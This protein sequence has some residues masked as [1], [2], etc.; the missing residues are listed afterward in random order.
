MFSKG[1]NPHP[2]VEGFRRATGRAISTKKRRQLRFAD[3]VRVTRRLIGQTAGARLERG[4]VLFQEFIPENDHDIRVTVI[5]ERCFVF[6]RDVRPDDFRASGSGRISY[7]QEEQVP[8]DAVELAFSISHEF[9]FQ[10]MAYDFVRNPRDGQLRLL[11]I[12]FVFN[13]AAVSNCPGYFDDRLR[14]VPGSV[15][16]EDAIFEDLL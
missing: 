3:V 6:R 9:G 4:Y 8:R 7:F 2:P 5:G 11:E 1:L 14:W 12:S 16:P 13:S 15:R 10:S